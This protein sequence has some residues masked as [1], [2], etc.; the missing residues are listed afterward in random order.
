M[1]QNICYKKKYKFKI[2]KKTKIIYFFNTKNKNM[3]NIKSKYI[4]HGAVQ[5]E[6]I[7]LIH[8]RLDKMENLMSSIS[9]NLMSLNSN[10]TKNTNDTINRDSLFLNTLNKLF[11]EQKKITSEKQISIMENKELQKND[12]NNF[13]ETTNF[14]QYFNEY[15]F[16]DLNLKRY[17]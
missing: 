4:T 3:N 12:Y 6:S 9:T 14:T 2:K 15:I 7:A 17:M 16:M 8:S 13:F 10:H 1:L 11:E 5:D